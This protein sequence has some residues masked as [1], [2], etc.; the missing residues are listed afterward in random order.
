MAA[1]LCHSLARRTRGAARRG[2]L[3]IAAISLAM[4]FSVW[5][6]GATGAEAVQRGTVLIVIGI[7]VY[8]VTRRTSPS[9]RSGCPVLRLDPTAVD[10]A[11][12]VVYSAASW[13]KR[14]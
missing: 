2:T 3:A 14:P 9:A 11:I 10:Y 1:E 5:M 12:L 8:V 7:P 4:V 13:V 6:A